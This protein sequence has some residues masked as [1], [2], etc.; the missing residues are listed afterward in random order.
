MTCC[1]SSGAADDV[2]E[3]EKR[4]TMKFELRGRVPTFFG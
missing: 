1:F 3:V 4:L 2:E